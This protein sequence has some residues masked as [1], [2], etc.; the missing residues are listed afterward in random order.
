MKPSEV[1]HAVTQRFDN[2]EDEL[3]R[4][5]TIGKLIEDVLAGKARLPDVIARKRVRQNRKAFE[6][7]EKYAYLFITLG[8]SIALFFKLFSSVF[9]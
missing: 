7:S 9:R 3:R 5:A 2:D 4:G 1:L 6:I 8:R